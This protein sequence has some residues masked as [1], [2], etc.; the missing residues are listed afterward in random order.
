MEEK[1]GK[2][3]K[4]VNSIPLKKQKKQIL[5]ITKIICNQIRQNK[6]KISEQRLTRQDKLEI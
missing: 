1:A 3:I 6:G 5:Y 2:P 4:P